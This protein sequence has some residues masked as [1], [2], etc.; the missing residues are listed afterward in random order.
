M[1][2]RD[3][4]P[5]AR[6]PRRDIADVLVIGDGVIGL[7][8][9]L[10]IARA[11]GTCCVLGRDSPGSAS[12]ASAGIL[13]PGVGPAAPGVRQTMIAARDRFPDLVDWLA[14]RTGIEVPLD[15]SGVIELT[16]EGSGLHAAD[17]LAEARALAPGV[18]RSLE[19]AIDP[20]FDGWLHPN[21]GFVDNVRLLEAMREAARCEW[22]VDTVEGR[23]ARV[24][25]A[26][27]GWLVVTDDGRRHAATTLV[28]AAG[29]WSPLIP[30]LP[31]VLPIEPMRGQMLALRGAPLRRAVFGPDCYA[32][33]RGDRTLVGSTVEQV[34]FDSSTTPAALDRLRACAAALVPGLAGAEVAGAWAGLRPMTPDGLPLLGRDPDVPSVLYACGH[35]KNGILLAALT[36]DCVAALA[37]GRSPPVDLT[38]FS[39]DRFGR[40]EG[41]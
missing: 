35:S 30:G 24:E 3:P 18:L 13:S 20:A 5:P 17:G 29:A 19:P 23:A 22:G 9:S 2:R 21:D 12:A 39:V 7:A 16:L 10:A 28:V 37:A 8:V 27:S 4:G 11:G 36:G 6:T 41:H 34:G 33:P 25:P 31:R 15:R 32:V 38:P 14:Q 26:P 40:G 1:T